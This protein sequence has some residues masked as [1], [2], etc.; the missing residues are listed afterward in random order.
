MRSSSPRPSACFSSPKREVDKL[1][2]EIADRDEIAETSGRQAA[3]VVSTVLAT[4]ALAAI[5]VYRLVLK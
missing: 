5:V 2:L 4:M 3:A 1:K